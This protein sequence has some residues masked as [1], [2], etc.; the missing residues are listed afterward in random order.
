MFEIRFFISEILNKYYN[1]YLN[2]PLNEIKKMTLGDLFNNEFN[3]H[4]K[5][6]NIIK[7]NKN[8]SVI[9]FLNDFFKI[10][11]K[12]SINMISIPSLG[13]L[14]AKNLFIQFNEIIKDIH[15]EILNI[16]SVHSAIVLKNKDNI[17]ILLDNR[18]RD[19]L[20]GYFDFFGGTLNIEDIIQSEDLSLDFEKIL[21]RELEEELGIKI[22]ME[23]LKRNLNSK[24]VFNREVIS[25]RR[26][27]LFDD[28]IYILELDNLELNLPSI[29]SH[30]FIYLNV[31]KDKNKYI[32][33][34]EKLKPMHP[35][36]KNT[37]LK[38]YDIYYGEIK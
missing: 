20:R 25:Y 32:E 29:E 9:E 30:S 4:K 38:I 8:K 18:N 24:P 15:E 5:L 21:K 26:K 3:F 14:E 19:P 33:N 16:K 6:N 35:I 23:K 28:Y 36:V 13:N 2:N 37:C 27:H 1:I 31:D 34:L 12:D 7:N 17:K 22:N 10:F 11:K